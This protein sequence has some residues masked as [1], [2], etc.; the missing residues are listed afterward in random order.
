MTRLLVGALDNPIS[1]GYLSSLDENAS[2]IFHL[3][4]RTCVAVGGI[5][6]HL[7]SPSQYLVGPRKQDETTL[8]PSQLIEEEGKETATAQETRKPRSAIQF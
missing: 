7:I 6:A 4:L 5:Y 1:F 2:K 3:E 8:I